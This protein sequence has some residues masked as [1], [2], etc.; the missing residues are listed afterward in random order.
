MAVYLTDLIFK[1]LKKEPS[2]WLRIN[3]IKSGML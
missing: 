2:E 1:N 3:E